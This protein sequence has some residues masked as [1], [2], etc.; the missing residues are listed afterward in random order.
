MLLLAALSTSGPALGA[1]HTVI[2][3]SGRQI[4][5][6]TRIERLVAVGPGALRLVT[7]LSAGSRVVGIERLE[8]EPEAAGFRPYLDALPE[9]FRE[10]PVIGAGGAG[11]LPN[12]EMVAACNAELVVAVGFDSPAAELL[13]AQSGVPVV[14]LSYGD[15]GVLRE[16]IIT[17][18]ELLGTILGR[19]ER[20]AELTAY[21][22]RQMEDIHRRTADIP[23]D[24]RPT[25][26]FAGIGYRGSQGLVSTEAGYLPGQLVNATNVADRAGNAGHRFIN[27]EQLLLWNPE[28]IFLDLLGL[29]N[30]RRDVARNAAFYRS[31]TAV[32]RQ[33]VYTLMPHNSYNTNV[34]IALANAWFIG[35][36][37]YPER[38][39]DVDF[40]RRQE[41][42]YRV[43]LGI[44]APDHQPAYI[45]VPLLAPAKRD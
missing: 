24:R 9:S 31:L 29:P 45:Q 43:F 34:E 14:V 41:E 30:I 17:S 42:I 22:R 26:Y 3:L 7:Y 15:L 32:Q 27:P 36:I 40:T 21:I 13:Q 38:F 20:A 5:L 35:S 16:E 11:R 18:L 6:P 23:A 12:P 33:R 25:V 4:S 44:A 1:T 10:L 2:D 8:I 37:L 39:A 19:R 28:V